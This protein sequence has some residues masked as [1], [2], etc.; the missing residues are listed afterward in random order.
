[1]TRVLSRALIGV[2]LLGLVRAPSAGL[3][4]DTLPSVLSDQEFWALT[5]KFSEPDGY[6]RSNSGSPDNLLSN[7]NIVSTVAAALATRVKPSGV[8]LGVGPE[9]NFTYI[10]AIRPRFAVV[11]DIRR[12]NLHLHLMYKALF[13][14]SATRADFVARL[15]TR[16][17]PAGLEPNAGVGELMTA[18]L[19]AE[20][21]DEAAFKG[22]LKA[23]TDHLTRTRRF[24]LDAGDLAGI[25]YVYRNFHQFGPAINYTSSIGRSSGISYA[26]LMATIDRETGVP[27]TYL[28]SEENFSIVK[29]MQS[30]NLIV[31]VVGDFAGPKALRMVG[32]YLKERG[33]T[34]TA[35]Y[36]SNVEM[37]LQRNG[38]WRA[39]CA[40]VAAM[41]L[42]AASTF[43]RPSGSGPGSLSS[44]VS[45]TADCAGK[46]A[47][48]AR[49][50]GKQ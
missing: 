40:N 10:A 22:N 21:G 25:E 38:A 11:T 28:A 24:P 26:T 2:L 12:G 45:E 48:A 49:P 13:E 35:F 17:R 47:G 43:V 3:A 32:A 41:P 33:A 29:A 27:R 16:R 9:Q 42:D 5:E 44:M 15:F 39:F 23:I 6:F 14:L 7:E 8:Y 37:Y 31:P 18:F 50:P 34:V 30:K 19:N 4:R 1:V 36:V 46:S 20:A